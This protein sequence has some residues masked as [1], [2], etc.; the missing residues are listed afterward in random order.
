MT[1]QNNQYNLF[2]LGRRAA[3][4][5]KGIEENPINDEAEP[6]KYIWWH[7]GWE[8]GKNEIEEEY[9]G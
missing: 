5:G 2:H 7:E 3:I 4:D 8:F 1:R 9:S 6:E